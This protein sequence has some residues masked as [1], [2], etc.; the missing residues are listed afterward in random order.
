MSDPATRPYSSDDDVVHETVE[1]RFH[2]LLRQLLQGD[3][4]QL[5]LSDATAFRLIMRV[6]LDGESHREAAK[7]GRCRETDLLERHREYA[8]SGLIDQFLYE[9]QNLQFRL[10]TNEGRRGE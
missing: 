2:E 10:R 1:R 6:I 4:S 5:D 3:R 7:H 8:D 9:Y